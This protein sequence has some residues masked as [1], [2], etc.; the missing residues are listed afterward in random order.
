MAV[1]AAAVTVAATRLLH[2]R[3]YAPR[4]LATLIGVPYAASALAAWAGARLWGPVVFPDY[5]G[6][7]L[8]A[9][10]LA[11]A[12]VVVVLQVAVPVYSFARWRLV[13]ALPALFLSAAATWYQFL[14]VGGESDVLWLWVIGFG[15][16]LILGTLAVLGIEVGVRRVV[17]R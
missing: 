17:G 8:L 9:G 15:P 3:G 2:G 5:Q 4:T 12:F 13:T 1:A 6:P 16:L 14:L 10:W 7:L 11:G